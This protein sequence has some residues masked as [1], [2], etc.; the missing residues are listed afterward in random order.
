MTENE[1]KELNQR[2]DQIEDLNNAIWQLV[3]YA[4]ISETECVKTIS[5]CITEIIE[6]IKEKMQEVKEK[7]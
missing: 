4:N 5:N 7:E 3:N 2:L 6:K 1:Q